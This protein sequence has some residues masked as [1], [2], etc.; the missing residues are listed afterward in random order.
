LKIRIFGSLANQKT[1][2]RLRLTLKVLLI[3]T[4]ILQIEAHLETTLA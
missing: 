4:T 1:Y 2:S 3:P